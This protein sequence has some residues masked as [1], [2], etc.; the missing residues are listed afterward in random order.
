VCY[1]VSLK[2]NTDFQTLK[3]LSCGEI[4]L[5][6]CL[7]TQCKILISSLNKTAQLATNEEEPVGKAFMKYL[8][9]LSL[10]ADNHLYNLHAGRMLLL[11]NKP[12]EAFSCL[13][14]AVGLISQL[15]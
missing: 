15:M 11:Q 6:L 9:A 4:L 12:E 13:Q 10:G 2:A 8:D 7:E 3:C 14:V 5:F 1:Q